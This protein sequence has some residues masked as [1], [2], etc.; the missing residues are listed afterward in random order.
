MGNPDT[1]PD[2]ST[3]VDIIVTAIREELEQRPQIL[4]AIGMEALIVQVYFEGEKYQPRAV[5]LRPEFKSRPRPFKG[6][7]KPVVR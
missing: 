5:V 7:T 4:E 1:R 3:R 6:G 2:R